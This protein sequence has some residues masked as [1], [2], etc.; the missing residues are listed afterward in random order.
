MV[1]EGSVVV[2]GAS[3]AIGR[4]VAQTFLEANTKV[5]WCSRTL[6]HFPY[7]TPDQSYVHPGSRLQYC[8]IDVSTNELAKSSSRLVLQLAGKIDVLVNCVGV[9]HGALFLM[10]TPES[11]VQNMQV[12]FIGPMVMTQLIARQMIRQRSGS[13]VHIGSTAG[14]NGDPGTFAYGSSKA[15]LMFAT[16]V[17]ARE[18]GPF[19]IRVNSIAPTIVDSKMANQMDPEHR[20]KLINSGAIKRMVN[21]REVAELV[22]FLASGQSAMI[23][24]QIVRL[25]GDQRGI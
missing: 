11:I 15:A 3:G 16:Q 8:K 25:D 19:G 20:S 10:T 12:N 14:L 22:R 24:G 7:Q 1:Q 23:T 21:P 17:M 2:L 18:L 9:S 6:D 13:I 4:A 5:I